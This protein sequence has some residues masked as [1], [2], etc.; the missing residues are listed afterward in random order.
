MDCDLWD[1]VGMIA[2]TAKIKKWL[3]S[4]A[5]KSELIRGSWEV[6]VESEDEFDV[7]TARNP[8]FPFKITIFVSEHVATLAINTG[9]STDEFDVADRMKMY[10]KML[11]LN[12]D[13]SLVKTGLLG[14]DDEV[15]VLV[16]FDLA[17]LS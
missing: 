13:Y 4:N 6:E 12:A 1:V 8:T 3:E 9:M 15:V 14:E 17:S 5:K 2:W 7:I 16:D 11:H 10:K